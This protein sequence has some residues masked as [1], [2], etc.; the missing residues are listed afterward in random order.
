MRAG[1]LGDVLLL[2]RAIGALRRHGWTAAILAPRA[3]GSTLLGPGDSEV[4][5]LIDWD[6][7]DV[8]ALLDEG[9][10]VPQR[11]ADELRRFD[12]ALVYSRSEPLVAQLRTMIPDALAVDPA[13]PPGVHA[14]RWYA[15]P[16]EALGL[17]TA[18]DPAP[19][20][21]TA[22]ER[23]QAAHWLDRLPERFLAV[24]PGS[25]SPAKNWRLTRV[26]ALVRALSPDHAW[27]LVSGPA[28]EG[29]AAALTGERGAVRAREL[30]PRVLGA[31]LA[32][33]G[34]F[35]GNDSGVTHL[36]AAI[37]A[38]TPALVGPTE[39]AQWTPVGPAVTV[40]RAPHGAM[41]Q[42]DVEPVLAAARQCSRP[43]RQSG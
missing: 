8:A 15:G 1:A 19:L 10:T 26:A 25:G 30:S 12:L 6:R 27:L 34:L 14:A 40:L 22:D 17:D 5:H 9:A 3:S 39:P 21:P 13:P 38:P 42:L 24:H 20:L 29:A 18:D 28:D 16:L 43:A 36:A 35:V 31:L 4:D 11:L 32:Q 23:A 2:R 33:A 37:G 41:D 7:A